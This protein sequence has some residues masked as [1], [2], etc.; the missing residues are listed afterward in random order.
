V[1]LV[2][3]T[4][5][6]V[7][8]ERKRFDAI[9]FLKNAD[10]SELLCVTTVSVG[11]LASGYDP[12]ALPQLIASLAPFEILYLTIEAALCFGRTYRRLKQGGN[13]IG[14]NDLWIA[15]I[16][17]AAGFPVVTRNV[18]EF[19]RVPGLRVKGY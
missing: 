6:L 17:L 12:Q 18:S 14:S 19:A 9:D 1:A 7:D 13:L 15:S 4:C 11:E 3:D 8:L 5:F 16:A 10:P 2:L